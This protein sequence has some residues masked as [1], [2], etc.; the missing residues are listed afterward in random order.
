MKPYQDIIIITDVDGTLANNEHRVSAKNKNAIAH[1]VEQGGHFAV[2]TGRTQKNVVPYM[3]GLAVNVPCILY[4]GG[5]LFSW[6]EQRFIK[7][8]HMSGGNF[9]A[10]L[11]YCMSKFPQMCVEVF[12][13]EQLYVIT[14]P[15]NID[16]H[17]E[18]EKQEFVYAEL[19]DI[20]DKVWI[21]IIFCDCHEN[22][23]ACQELLTE[24]N[25]TDKT[26]SFFSAI[27]YLE[28]VDSQVSKGNM[29]NELLKIPA[30][31]GKKVIAAGDFQN[32]IEMLKIADCG[33]A[34][35][36]ALEEVKKAADIIGV[37]NDEDLLHYIIY[38]ILPEVS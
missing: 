37:S 19:D 1:F 13:Q 28:I 31:H 18:R 5:A 3:G 8:K 23:L 35:A 4:N 30:Y 29:L 2:A 21:K 32:D 11:K 9:E 6:Q 38:N 14:D 17:M 26:N 27:T 15:A 24:F 36:N 22:L 7:I 20:L 10:Y 25:L 12:T 33:I 34:P 16:E